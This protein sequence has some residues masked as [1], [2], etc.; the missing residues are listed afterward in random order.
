M[1]LVIEGKSSELMQSTLWNS[2]FY[3]WRCGICPDMNSGLGKAESLL[4][5]GR[6]AEKFKE[7]QQIVSTDNG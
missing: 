7:I 5:S 2:G 1:Q 4:I 6:V 3:L